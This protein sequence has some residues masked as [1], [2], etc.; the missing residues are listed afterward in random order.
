MIS[1]E[2]LILTIGSI[3]IVFIIVLIIIKMSRRKKEKESSLKTD[4]TTKT[5]KELSAGLL[6]TA[7]YFLSEDL[8]LKRIDKQD[9]SISESGKM[10]LK[11]SS[12]ENQIVITKNTKGKLIET[13]EGEVKIQ[14]WSLPDLR[15]QTDRFL[16]PLVE[17]TC[18]S[19]LHI[20]IMNIL[21]T[22]NRHSCIN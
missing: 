7:H 11:S 4:F 22:N 12:F 18:Y 19:V 20:T 5:I 17:M 10:V 14:F 16:H 1:D 21:Q 13:N 9:E 2:K 15:L 8:I 6:K 3:F